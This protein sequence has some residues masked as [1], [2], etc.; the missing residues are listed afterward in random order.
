MNEGENGV[1]DTKMP[2]EPK[3]VTQIL[4]AYPEQIGKQ[5]QSH[6]I[7]KESKQSRSLSRQ[8]ECL[9][10]THS[11]I[12]EKFK[13]HS[14]F[15]FVFD[16]ETTADVKNEL[17][18]G[19][20]SVFGIEKSVQVNLWES[21]QLTREMLDKPHRHYCFYNPNQLKPEELELLTSWV[22]RYN[23]EK[24]EDQPKI[25][26]LPVLKFIKYEFYHWVHTRS[27]LCVG[28]N[29]PFDLSRLAAYWGPSGKDYTNGFRLV[30]CD[31]IEYWTVNHL[32]IQADW[33]SKNCKYHPYI[34]VRKLG[35]KKAKFA[36]RIVRQNVE[37][38]AKPYEGEFLDTATLGR[39]LLGPGDLS[40]KGLCHRAGVPESECKFDAENL[41]GKQLSDKYIDYAFQDVRATFALY[42]RLRDL[43]RQHDLKTSMSHIYSEASLGKAYFK[44]MG[45]PHFQKQHP[46]TDSRF[47]GIASQAYYGGRSE[48]MMR[49]HSKEC[50]MV[51]FT[52]QYPSVNALMDNQSLLLAERIERRDNTEWVRTFLKDLAPETLL[53]KKIWPKLRS[54]VKLTPQCDILP[55]RA[56]LAAPA[57]PPNIAVTPVFAAQAIWYTLADV[58]AAV[59]MN[60]NKIPIVEQAY[61]LIPHG[62]VQTQPKCIFGVER[63]LIDLKKDDLF[64]TVIEM[65]QEIKASI[66]TLKKQVAELNCNKQ[67]IE[68]L[69]SM[70]QGLKFLANSTSYGVLAEF[71]EEDPFEVPRGIQL[72]IGQGLPRPCKTTRFETP[73]KYYS[74]EIASFITGGGRLLFA[75][76]E[77][78]GKDRGISHAL[79]DTDSMVFIRPDGM[80]REAFLQ[81]ISEMIET[82]NCLSP[83]K[84]G[85]PL[86]KSEDVNVVDDIPEP[87][88]V[89]AISS[90]RY[91]LYNKRWK[92]DQE[93]WHDGIRLRK[94]TNHGLGSYINPP[95][96][97]SK[98]PVPFA[99]DDEPICT[100]RWIDDLWTVAI[101]KAESKPIIDDT[102]MILEEDIYG[103]L[104]DVPAISKET[105]STWEVFKQIEDIPHIRPFSFFVTLPGI[106]EWMVDERIRQTGQYIQTNPE[107]MGMGYYAPF[108][109]NIDEIKANLTRK[110]T[111]ELTP[112]APIAS[113]AEKVLH[114]FAHPEHKAYPSDGIGQLQKQPVI[115]EAL[116]YC[117]KETQTLYS[118]SEDGE[119]NGTTLIGEEQAQ[120]FQIEAPENLTIKLDVPVKTLLGLGVSKE[121][122]CEEFE[123]SN[124]TL[125]NIL[126]GQQVSYSLMDRYIELFQRICSERQLSLEDFNSSNLQPGY[127]ADELKALIA[128]GWTIPMLAH[129]LGKSERQVYR[130]MEG[131]KCKGEI[132]WKIRNLLA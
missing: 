100:A 62:M 39:A 38:A 25:K 128:Q 72:H 11:D 112:Y 79:G 36:F 113:L 104:G 80:E 40:L 49:L 26:L 48:V 58:C 45:V 121:Q 68:R 16:C 114:Y 47:Y 27:A 131:E 41:H 32:N 60:P 13:P 89:L 59:I 8:Q 12:A 51:D 30:L 9:K 14:D 37:N 52:S 18:F 81:H 116:A 87:L 98:I 86:L 88:Y 85:I 117:G 34:R 44:A 108:S 57:D 23:C 50:M 101:R 93:Q 42:K 82:V 66:K 127:V 92:D 77:R 111:H 46:N 70:E 103:L 95:N 106:E 4:R 132:R 43:Y 124:K 99:K 122:I 15:V 96:Y 5:E 56:R 22:V 73:G 105:V 102:E 29:L 115:V 17:R 74:G 119:S 7:P 53:D 63:Y 75:M 69:E 118:Y 90:K 109:T 64:K 2:L 67:E 54:M 35:S 120:I 3:V 83:Y 10:A 94:C 71:I 110:D 28:H 97:Q 61:E 78:L 129:E 1:K 24:S 125:S 31:C 130:W 65:R 33:E 21:G 107:L 91:A 55:V 19:F 20:A 84:P 123:I 76:I 6:E 126:S